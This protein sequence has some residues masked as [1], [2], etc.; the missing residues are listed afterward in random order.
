MVVVVVV[1]VV[2]PHQPM[3]MSMTQCNGSIAS[4]HQPTSLLDH[5]AL[6]S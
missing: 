1:V 4:K 3:C 6:A 5:S 2:G